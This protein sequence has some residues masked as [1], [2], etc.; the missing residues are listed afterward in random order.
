MLHY[1]VGCSI[2]ALGF[3]VKKVIDFFEESDIRSVQQ[4]IRS[5][6]IQY[7]KVGEENKV[8]ARSQNLVRRELEYMRRGALISFHER[9]LNFLREISNDL[10]TAKQSSFEQ[11]RI[12]H[13]NIKHAPGWQD[14]SNSTHTAYLKSKNGV[15]ENIKRLKT[16]ELVAIEEAKN[17]KLKLNM[18]RDGTTHG[19]LGGKKAIAEYLGQR[20]ER[21]KLIYTK[22]KTNNLV[23]PFQGAELILECRCNN[24][25]CKANIAPE[26]QYCMVCGKEQQQGIL[27]TARKF[28]DI[29]IACDHC[30]I[31]IDETLP[32]CFNC[33]IE[34][35][36][37]GLIAVYKV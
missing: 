31:K 25:D 11:I 10:H 36:P 15:H 30:G 3:A 35:D 19:R 7:C 5:A 23:L 13:E 6:E 16:L 22:R 17:S 8:I 37:F 24:S 27:L 2:L 34:N 18:L 32:Y 14:I 9:R 28:V 4:S 33:G 21:A 29:G 12:M 20:Q 26:M 1:I